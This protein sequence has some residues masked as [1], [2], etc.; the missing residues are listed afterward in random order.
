MD[1]Q[2]IQEMLDNLD[3][4]IAS[5][6]IDLETYHKLT[7]KWQ[8][9]L[10]PPTAGEK[11]A[12]SISL[13]DAQPAVAQIA[14]PECGA[15]LEDVDIS[16][17]SVVR[18]A[19]CRATFTFQHAQEETERTHHELQLWLEQMVVEAGGTGAVDAASRRY[20]FN[21]RL[22]PALQLEYRRG[23]E[24]YENAYEHP[25]VYLDVL[26]DMPGYRAADHVLV[27]HH[28][29]VPGMRALSLKVNSPLVSSFAIGEEDGRK[30][31]DL[32]VG[33]TSLVH[34]ANV[35]RLLTRPGH[36]AYASAKG[37]LLA[38]SKEYSE[39]VSM[40]LE[41]GYKEYIQAVRARID[42]VARVFDVLEIITA[43]EAD[44][45][46]QV[47]LEELDAAQRELTRAHELAETSTYSPLA[48][49]PFKTG[50]ERDQKS[51]SLLSALLHSYQTASR[52]RP[53]A[54]SAYHTDL[55]ALLAIIALNCRDPSQLMESS[56]EIESIILAHRG[57]GTL[58]RLDD[59]N[60]CQTRIN[61]GRHRS[62]FDSE[63]VHDQQHYWHPFWYATVRYAAKQG[64]LRVSGV[65]KTA[66]GLIDAIDRKA[67]P[68][69]FLDDT[70]RHSAVSQ[71]LEQPQSGDGKLFL[72]SCMSSAAATQSI[73]KKIK[74]MQNIIDAHVAGTGLLYLPAVQVE[75]RSK[76]E[77]RSVLYIYDEVSQHGERIDQMLSHVRP[78]FERYG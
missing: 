28:E 73:V 38:L 12:A 52:G 10:Q 34:L 20:I 22:Y 32:D 13:G 39:Y 14:C 18:C 65:E 53:L 37:N 46:S 36:E 8:S 27:H 74:S 56:Q 33:T 71:A 3:R 24:P 26:R 4:Q 75:Y 21:E 49:L 77:R 51:L 61:A 7:A 68:W 45:A 66:Y 58:Y 78:F 67:S 60:W 23:M 63:K 31:R 2:S 55:K 35:A 48:V 54:F 44:F 59:W 47:Y 70:P 40:P 15:S 64:R 42:A 57:Q 69:I 6:K 50:L 16:P 5:G 29:A 17:G 62:L 76:A 11:E 25:F 9:K 1:N 19:F 43:P 72:P 30:L 41:P